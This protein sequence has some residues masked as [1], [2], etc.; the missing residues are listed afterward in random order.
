MQYL[1]VCS[2]GAISGLHC[3]VVEGALLSIQRLGDDDGANS[4]LYVKHTVA[5]PTCSTGGRSQRRREGHSVTH[6]V[7]HT[8]TV[9]SEHTPL[10]IN[11]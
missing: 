5:V 2:I 11:M 4:L 8:D 10:M 3:K 1:C 6:S 7:N 9:Y